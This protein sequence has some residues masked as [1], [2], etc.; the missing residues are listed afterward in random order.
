[1]IK[2]VW[3]R[4]GGGLGLVLVVL[5]VGFALLGPLLIPDQPDHIDIRSRFAAPSWRHLAGTDALGRDLLARLAIGGRLALGVALATLAIALPVGTLWDIATAGTGRAGDAAIVVVF[6]IVAAFPSL[7]LAL[8]A[9]ALLG[10]G[11]VKVI[12]LV[13]LTLMPEFGRVARAQT[14]ALGSATYLEAARTVGVGR[15]RLWR[16]HLLPNIAGPLLVLASMDI[17]T[18]ITIEAG[19]SFLGV[20]VPP[21]AASWGALLYD[22]YVHLDQ[23]VWPVATACAML[24]LSTLGFTLLG[25]AL[26][27]AADPGLRLP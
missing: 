24:V 10:P 22:G 1:M 14:L 2:R 11:L 6:D 16:R 17:P 15:W 3:Q 12:L 19:L 27:D 25:E 5:V 8:A 26:R 23:S 13:A 9:V 21:P 20:G 18:V 7:L 4:A